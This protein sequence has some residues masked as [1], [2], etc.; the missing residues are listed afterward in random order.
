M[1][2]TLIEVAGLSFEDEAPAVV[3]LEGIV[4]VDKIDRNSE[5]RLQAIVGWDGKVRFGL[6]M[7]WDGMESRVGLYVCLGAKLYA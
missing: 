4:E 2:R 1:W 6:N 7:G 5:K 3:D